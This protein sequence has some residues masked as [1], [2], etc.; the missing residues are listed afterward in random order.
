VT[1]P[2]RLAIPDIAADPRLVERLIGEGETL[3]VER[4]ERDP[5]DGLGATVASFANMLGGWLLI[6]VD[7][8]GDV[9]GYEPPGSADLQ[10][11]IRDLLRAQVDPLP[12]FAAIAVDVGAKRV[13][14]VHV[15]ESSDTPHITREGVIYVRNPGGK[16]RVTDHRDVLALARRGETARI[17]AEGR[18]Y[19]LPLVADAMRTP[20]R[21]YGD[22]P[23]TRGPLQE[24]IVRATPYTIA[25]GFADRA[26]S[27]QIVEQVNQVA[28]S[29]VPPPRLPQPMQQSPQAHVEARARGVYCQAG[30][31]G[32]LAHVDAVVDAGGVIALRIAE[33]G[34]PVA[35]N[36][37]LTGSLRPLIEGA[38]S[39]L[40]AL[41]AY[42]RAAIGLEIRGAADLMV[43]LDVGQ[44]GR[45]NPA[46]LLDGDTLR[47]GGDI[48]APTAAFDIDELEGR[49]MRELGR[50]ARLSAWEPS[51][52][53]ADEA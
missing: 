7:D 16:Q 15:A 26:M 41:D 38:T 44:Q 27:A 1:S 49:W 50:A 8:D 52:A 5:K 45:V 46:D 10:D 14:V 11:Y 47:V 51:S 18:L 17:D 22:N 43:A 12:P 53:P 31:T 34:D 48:A 36:M 35:A 33:R 29:L 39:L 23:S 20:D 42:G 6:G 32:T 28:V 2:R 9:V 24:V 37:V 13:G 3:F 25:G 4:K 19:G 21:I 30:R 40:G